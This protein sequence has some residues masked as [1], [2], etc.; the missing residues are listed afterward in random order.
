MGPW[1]E[2]RPEVIAVVPS[3]ASFSRISRSGNPSSEKRALSKGGLLS[4]EGKS[5]GEGVSTGGMLLMIGCDVT[6]AAVGRGGAGEA[7]KGDLEG[8]PPRLLKGWLVRS[9]RGEKFMR[10]GA[11]RTAIWGSG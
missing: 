5:R 1:E 4:E 8:V 9:A 6:S 7:N 11:A 10:R 2:E 3:E